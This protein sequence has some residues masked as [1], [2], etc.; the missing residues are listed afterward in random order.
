MSTTS[1]D[2]VKLEGFVSGVRTAREVAES[3]QASVAS[4]SRTTIAAC[5]GYVSV[6]ALGALATLLDDMG[7][8]E[9]FV[10]TI[11]NELLAADN[12]DG[13]TYTVSDSR[14]F[15]ALAASGVGTPPLRWSSTRSR[16]SASRR[17]RASST[18]RSAPPTG[19][20]CTRTSTWASPVSPAG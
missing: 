3:D 4:L 2:P 12:H 1:A 15:T 20:W 16:S 8:N 5:D 19:T 17:H 10:R 13:G 7:A 11:R 18:T 9:T 14:L 6:P